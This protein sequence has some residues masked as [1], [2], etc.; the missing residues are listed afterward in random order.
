MKVLLPLPCVT[1]AGLLTVVT[2]FAAGCGSSSISSSSSTPTATTTTVSSSSSTAMVGASITLTATVT[3]SAAAGTVAFVDSTD[4]EALCSSVTVSSG[5]AIC[6]FKIGNI[7][8]GSHTFTATFT[9]SSATNYASSSG[10]TTVTVNALTATTTTLSTGLTNNTTTTGTSFTLTATVSSGGSV[11]TSTSGTITFTDTTAST[12]LCSAVAVSSSGTATCATSFSTAGAHSLTA[13]YGGDSTYATSTSSAVSVAVTASGTTATTVTLSAATLAPSAGAADTLTAKVYDSTGV[14]LETGA[15]GY[16]DFYDATDSTDLGYG[17]VSS[18]TATLSP[19]FS[20][21]GS[22]HKI[23]ATYLGDENYAE[24]S[25]SNEVDITVAA[26]TTTIEI[27]VSPSVTT[28]GSGVALAAIVTP[29]T[30]TGTVTF[31]DGG[32]QIATADLVSGSAVAATT[33]TSLTQGAHTITAEYNSVTSSSATVTVNAAT[34]GSFSSGAACGQT[35]DGATGYD[36]LTTGTLIANNGSYSTSTADQN[37]ICVTGASSYLTLINPAITKTGDSTVDGDSSFY[38]LNAAVLDYNGGNLTIDGG[39]SSADVSALTSSNSTI[40]SDGAG[41]NMIYS[42]GTGTVTISNAAL[43]GTASNNHGIYA[44]GGGT[45]VANNV[46]AH[47]T[48]GTSSIIATDRGGGTVTV[49]GGT[50]ETDAGQTA[51]VYSTGSITV[52]N[53]TLIEE[54]G[55]VAT[56]EGDNEIYLNNVTMT[57]A[58]NKDHRG[59]FLYQSMSGDALNNSNTCESIAT[60]D[61]FVMKGGTY[62]YTDTTSGNSDPNHNCAAFEVYNQTSLA[63]LTDATVNNSCGTLLLS[64]YND[65]WTNSDAW[66]YATFKAYGTTLTGNIIV[67]YGCLDSSCDTR[68]IS[69]TAAITLNAD[70]SGTG[71]TLTGA[72]N[73]NNTGGGTTLTMDAASKWV[74]TGTSYLTDL[75]DADTTYSNITCQNPSSNCVYKNGTAVK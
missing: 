39:V 73:T 7:A 74:V 62:N 5:T 13:V 50:Y 24:S 46:Y 56:I 30:S 19:S 15:T 3:P 17:T 68:D 14:T 20:A 9:P 53:A 37:A 40:Y 43:Y 27:N 55:E 71:S 16:V 45:I 57:T 11:L 1:A 10:T 41:G 67:G 32:N 44:S 23:Y 63:I 33:I 12:T 49:N 42:Y 60:G 64:S 38:G 25:E 34:P 65:Q 59:V 52:N 75:T 26:V 8:T 31:Y 35:S 6:T 22:A 21:A 54:G 4:S 48:N 36:V 61:C 51:A 18:G 28:V 72:I 58:S 2:I 70:T 29:L 47:S 69:S 66:G